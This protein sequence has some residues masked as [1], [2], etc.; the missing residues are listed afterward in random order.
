MNT[1]NGN[2]SSYPDTIIELLSEGA[3]YLGLILT[4]PKSDQCSRYISELMRWN[5]KINLTS[6]TNDREVII[7]HFLD[8]FSFCKGFDPQPGLRLLDLGSGAGFPA[9][10]I[11][12]LFPDISVALIESNKKKSS[13][14]RHIIRTLNLSGVEVIEMRAES[15]PD[16]H[17]HRYDII[18]SRAFA[19]MVTIL[20]TGAKYLKRGGLI[21]L[22]RGPEETL[23]EDIIGSAGLVLDSR[24]D[25]TLPFSDYRRAIWI[26]RSGEIVPRGTLC[27]ETVGQ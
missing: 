25:L 21:V 8:S 1:L 14:L 4:D 27:S 6:I 13:F 2:K 11:K 9:L 26:F 23:S 22:S 20:N 16:L 17:L 15:L 18:T 7:K 24:I 3:G 12:V 5:R 19:D 10:P